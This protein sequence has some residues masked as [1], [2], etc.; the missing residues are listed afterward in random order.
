MRARPEDAFVLVVDDEPDVA[1]YL[2][3]MLEDAGF[4][5]AT[6]HDGDQ[7]LDLVK[8]RAPDLI[9]LDLVMPGKSGA[10]FLFALRR[11][12]AWA[13]IPVLIVT[14][15]AHDVLGKR[16][17]EK[18]LA[19]KTLSGPAVYLEKP[20]TPDSYVSAAKQQLGLETVFR[21]DLP[22]RDSVKSEVA[23]LLEDADPETV[24]NILKLLKEG[25]QVT[26]EHADRAPSSRGSVLVIDDEP[27]V[28]AYLSAFLADCGFDTRSATDPAAAV[29]D[30]KADPP[31]VIT[32]DIDMP[33][34]NGVEVYAELRAAPALDGTRVVVITAVPQKLQSMP[35]GPEMLREIEGYLTKPFEPD[36]L[37]ETVE[38]ACG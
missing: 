17:L 28:A 15:H 24:Q 8:Q 29:A 14:G 25:Q 33:G 16:D 19:E 23:K 36:A 13:R 10:R 4:Q 27:D 32:L 37:R 9:S 5:V 34:K 11:N 2:S 26:S 20:V 7:A 35:G 18:I 6:A 31:D 30:A 21:R 12:K 3:A 38:R 22:G 1:S